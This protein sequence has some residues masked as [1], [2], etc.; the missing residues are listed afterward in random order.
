MLLGQNRFKISHP[1]ADA[2]A[3][4]WI[5]SLSL[6][7]LLLFLLQPGLKR[8]AFLDQLLLERFNLFGIARRHSLRDFVFHGDFAPGNFRGVF[9][10]QLREL[11]FLRVGELGGRSGLVEPFHCKFV[12]RLH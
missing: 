8:F 5:S 11:F 6:P 1:P 4:F 7:H 2:Q 10:I 9:R 3:K 12:G